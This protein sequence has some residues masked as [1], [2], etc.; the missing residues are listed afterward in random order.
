MLAVLRTR[1]VLVSSRSLSTAH[2][3]TAVNP[4]LAAGLA[5]YRE[6]VKKVYDL[7]TP[8]AEVEKLIESLNTPKYH[9]IASSS[10]EAYQLDFQ[11]EIED[12]VEESLKEGYDDHGHAAGYGHDDGHGHGAHGPGH[13]QKIGETLPIPLGRWSPWIGALIPTLL[14]IG[15]LSFSLARGPKKER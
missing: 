6:K 12:K 14:S 1:V 8:F 11:K 3:P 5:E 13:G 10:L 4:D 7:K 15:A 2:A 9:L